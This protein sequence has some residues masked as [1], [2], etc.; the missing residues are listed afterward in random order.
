M[1]GKGDSV[2][3]R[4]YRDAAFPD[5]D[6]FPASMQAINEQESVMGAEWEATQLATMCQ[7]RK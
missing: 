6:E 1:R 7:C 2:W 3:I 5:D 4:G